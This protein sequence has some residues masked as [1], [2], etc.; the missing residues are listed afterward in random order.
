MEG[1]SE[2]TSNTAARSGP[3]ELE[4]QRSAAFAK[5]REDLCE[6]IY[7][8]HVLTWTS[9]FCR[10]LSHRTAYRRLQLDLVIPAQY[11]NELLHIELKSETLPGKTLKR[12]Q[13]LCMEKMLPLLG[14]PQI[15]SVYTFL[16]EM[17]HE[18]RLLFATPEINKSI[19]LRKEEPSFTLGVN[20]QEGLVLIKATCGEFTLRAKLIVEDEYPKHPLGIEFTKCS[21]PEQISGIFLFQAREIAR[22]LS[23]G[24]S[25]EKA[26][27]QSTRFL[28]QLGPSPPTKGSAK[29]K[30]VKITSSSL[31]DM[32]QDVAF[33]KKS[34]DLKRVDQAYNRQLHKYD[35]STQ[36]RRAARKELRKL[37]KLEFEKEMEREAKELAATE[38][39]QLKEWRLAT[40]FE[41]LGPQRSVAVI[42]RF[43]TKDFAFKL[44]FETS[45]ISGEKVF[46]EKVADLQNALEHKKGSRP[47]RVPTCGCW[48][49]FSELKIF[50]ES[51]PFDTKVC[52]R[53]SCKGIKVQHPEFDQ[54]PKRLERAWLKKQAAKREQQEVLDFLS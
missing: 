48:W 9:D 17:I 45:P 19:A 44:P 18:N 21:F 47:T 8:H 7:Q 40:G 38:E 23:I 43:L 33:L 34:T 1:S 39:E 20:D 46:P 32:K 51:P 27:Q 42:V 30:D 16:D 36:E 2:T 35:H 54:D 49:K 31:Q 14:K 37:N 29:L 10:L 6:V 3:E 12:L 11:P 25:K 53:E 5:D 26:I 50:I 22:K 28:G 4:E 41:D 52:P 24:V 15:A 13:E